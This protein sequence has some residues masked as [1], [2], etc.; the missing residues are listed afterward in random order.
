MDNLITL[1]VNSLLLLLIFNVL[2]RFNYPQL[3]VDKDVVKIVYN[4]FYHVEKF[5]SA[6]YS[7]VDGLLKKNQKKKEISLHNISTAER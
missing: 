4:F 1:N 3:V 7:K 2:R 6:D 5:S